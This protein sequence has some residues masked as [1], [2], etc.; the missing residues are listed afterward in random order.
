MAFEEN[1]SGLWRKCPGDLEKIPSLSPGPGTFSS[2][3]IVLYL[4]CRP[5]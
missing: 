1:V 4:L 5:L 2:S 3:S